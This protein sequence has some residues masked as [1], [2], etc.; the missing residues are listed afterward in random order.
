MIPPHESAHIP[1]AILTPGRIQEVSITCSK[2]RKILT[3]EA[4]ASIS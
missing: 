2:M 4:L 1:A 3:A